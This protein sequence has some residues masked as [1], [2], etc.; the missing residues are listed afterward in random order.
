MSALKRQSP[1]GEGEA[2]SNHQKHPESTALPALP[3]PTAS[4]PCIALGFLLNGRQIDPESLGDGLFEKCAAAVPELVAMGWPVRT[5]ER[6]HWIPAAARAVSIAQGGR[7]WRNVVLGMMQAENV[8]SF[9]KL[10]HFGRR[11]R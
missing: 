2:K 9:P 3:T 4:W 5:G 8:D 1:A 6:R 11:S 10:G 7:D